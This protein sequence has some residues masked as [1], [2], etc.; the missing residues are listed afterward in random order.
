M[1]PIKKTPATLTALLLGALIA[2]APDALLA[3]VDRG[4]NQPGAAGN[5][6]GGAAAARG[7]AGYN[8]PGA[9]GNRAAPAAGDR[10]A[11][12][13]GAAGNAPATHRDR[14]A[15]QAGAAGNRGGRGR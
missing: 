12:Q 11:N 14:G 7:D 15:N 10:G 9:A 1:N 2:M 13:P 8:Q 3:R 5:R 6:G 4:A